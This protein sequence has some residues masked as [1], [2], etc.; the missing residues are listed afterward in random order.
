MKTFI[1]IILIVAWVAAYLSVV[2]GVAHY[3]RARAL[4]MGLAT[5]DEYRAEKD[6]VLWLAVFLAGS[7]LGAA[8]Y[9]ATM[10]MGQ[11]L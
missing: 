7:L 2:Y 11:S 9:L 6:P 10:A 8:C 4:A 3:R 1:N 5:A